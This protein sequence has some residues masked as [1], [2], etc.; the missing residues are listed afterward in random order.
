MKTRTL[1]ISVSKRNKKYLDLIDDYSLEFDTNKSQT[2]F[3]IL[4]EYNKLRELQYS[5][6]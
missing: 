1:C 5:Q 4:D 3:R 6:K 2:V